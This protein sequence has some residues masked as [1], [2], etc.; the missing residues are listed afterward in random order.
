M[1]D[2]SWADRTEWRPIDISPPHAPTHEENV[3]NFGYTEL[4]RFDETANAPIEEF[5]DI[6][7]IHDDAEGMSPPPRTTQEAASVS[8]DNATA[9][10]EATPVSSIGAT[11]GPDSRDVLQPAGQSVDIPFRD[12]EAILSEKYAAIQ[13]SKDE[14]S[15][16]RAKPCRLEMGPQDQ[17]RRK[18]GTDSLQGLNSCKRILS[19]RGVDFDDTFAPVAPLEAIRG[20]LAVATVFDWEVDGIDVL[21]A[22]LNSITFEVDDVSEVVMVRIVRSPL[23]F[24]WLVLTDVFCH[25]KPLSFRQRIVTSEHHSPPLSER[26][27]FRRWPV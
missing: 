15:R 8:Y 2:Q 14:W 20:I 23:P 5:F 18:P 17:D 4:N 10:R 22:Y 26:S 13:N 6:D 9:S 16:M 25:L 19:T 7:A 21:Q 11:D 3:P 1:E 24:C 12:N 27:V